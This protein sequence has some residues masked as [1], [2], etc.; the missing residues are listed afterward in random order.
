LWIAPALAAA[1]AML[2]ALST[3]TTTE[4]GT[5]TLVGPSVRQKGG[6]TLELS[7]RAPGSET[8][9]HCASGD[10]VAPD[11]AVMFR[12]HLGGDRYLMMLG[13]DSATPWLTYFP[14]SGDASARVDRDTSDFLSASVVLDATPGK[15]RFVL[16]IS[17]RP[18]DRAAVE[19]AAENPSLLPE[20]I[21]AIDVALE[22]GQP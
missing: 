5:E 7:C 17:D 6:D 11:T 3:T 16:F 2:F 22:K 8:V 18:F 1:A 21:R 19:R 9:R 12:T 10:V 15:E 4:T 13:R 20:D 14:R